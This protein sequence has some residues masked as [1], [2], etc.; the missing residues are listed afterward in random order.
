MTM[1]IQLTTWPQHFIVHILRPKTLHPGG[2]R[3]RDLLF[4]RRTRWPQCN[5]ARALICVV[6]VWEDLHFLPN[7]IQVS[8]TST[9]TFCTQFYSSRC[10][11]HIYVLYA[12]LF[13]TGSATRS[14]TFCTHFMQV[15]ATRRYTFCRHF[16][17]VSAKRRSTF[18]TQFYSS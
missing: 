9:S 15:S 13:K 2:I 6:S 5:A 10:H 11:K 14:S 8:A 12:F 17:Q 3:T 18:Y 16:I 4:C 1:N 7:F